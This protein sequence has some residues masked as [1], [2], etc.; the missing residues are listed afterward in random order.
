LRVV[1]GFRWV[2]FS[3][4]LR[5]LLIATDFHDLAWSNPQQNEVEMD[6]LDDT[7]ATSAI[8][9]N[10]VISDDATLRLLTSST[11]SCFWALGG[12]KRI[13]TLIGNVC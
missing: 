1:G 13:W 3:P 10:T 5:S 9:K 2:I 7:W 12:G 6:N 11:P 8:P 4:S